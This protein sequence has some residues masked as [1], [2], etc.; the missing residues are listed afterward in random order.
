M[1]TAS[2][3]NTLTES[4]LLTLL[5]WDPEKYGIGVRS[6]DEQH[7]ILIALTNEMTRL[8][9]AKAHPTLL[10]GGLQ[11]TASSAQGG[12]TAA[13]SDAAATSPIG[14]PAGA[15][16]GLMGRIAKAAVQHS[17]AIATSASS[18]MVPTTGASCML[19]SYSKF[20]V[21]GFRQ[22]DP[23]LQRGSEM[24]KVIEDLVTYTC[25]YLLVEDH[26]LET[27][28][29]VDRAMQQQDHELFTCEVS[30]CF[31]LME[32]CSCQ[33]GDIRRLLLF[34]RLWLSGHIP[35]D[36]KYAP[37]LIEKGVGT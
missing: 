26:L 11:R 27:Y 4:E 9:V 28:A 23:D 29:Y 2:T 16:S 24:A 6:I 31:R 32:D 35:R 15:K 12:F 22:F 20:P 8:Y 34:L 7:K 25:K 37:M 33:V 14:S 21:C 1:P 17:H 18:P 19:G 3:S 5:E 13:N 36:R 10:I 30:Y